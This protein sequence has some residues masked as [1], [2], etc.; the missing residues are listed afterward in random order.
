MAGQTDVESLISNGRNAC[1][2][3]AISSLSH[4]KSR[5]SATQRRM[6]NP[7][8]RHLTDDLLEAEPIPTPR[9]WL[10]DIFE[11]DFANRPL[12][13]DV[14]C[15]RGHCVRLLANKEPEW[16]FLGLEIRGAL[17]HEAREETLREREAA[18]MV[19]ND[20]V[21]TSLPVGQSRRNVHHLAVNVM[22]SPRFEALLASIVEAASISSKQSKGGSGDDGGGVVA[23]VA[24]QFPDPWTRQRHRRR[25]LVGQSL[26]ASLARS[27][28]VRPGAWVYVS[29]DVPDCVSQA[30]SE[31]VSTGRFRWHDRNDR[32]V[33][34]IPSEKAAVHTASTGIIACEGVRHVP[35]RSW[36]TKS[37]PEVCD[38]LLIE[39]P[40]GT[41]AP[42][43]RELVCEQ[44]WRKVYRAIFIKL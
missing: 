13:I 6:A 8:S 40:L 26:A 35:F 43:E 34:H 24:I 31:L 17:V 12:F 29:S 7:F 44:L 25:R 4:A 33:D 27:Q 16:N 15:A 23:A 39:N 5:I 3:S 28:A 2:V 37:L 11:E 9:Q 36:K 38:G 14:G 21:T 30:A 10:E 1:G 41:D 32:W 19:M 42:S 22:D 20:N 18:R